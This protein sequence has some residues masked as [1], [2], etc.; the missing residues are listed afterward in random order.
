MTPFL[1]VHS[2]VLY[3]Y[4]YLKVHLTYNLVLLLKSVRMS[5][6]L[7]TCITTRNFTY[8]WWRLSAENSQLT[9]RGATITVAAE[10]LRHMHNL[11]PF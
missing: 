1:I 10:R 8:G 6:L 3:M 7:F 11:A 5:D 9:F 2:L 4:V